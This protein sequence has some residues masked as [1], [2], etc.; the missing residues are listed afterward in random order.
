MPLTIIRNDLT[1]VKADAIV[2]TANKT[3][4]P[5]GGVCGAVFAAA[6]REALAAECA[7]IGG[8]Q[9]GQAVITGAHA[10]PAKYII[11]TVA[12]VWRG[13]GHGEAATLA[14][15]YTA[16]LGLAVKHGC[17][18]VAFP[19]IASGVRGYPKDAALSAAVST[20][21][22]FLMKHELTVFLVVFDQKAYA[23]SGKLF[24]D[25]QS[26]IDQHYVD[27]HFEERRLAPTEE[28]MAAIA[29]KTLEDALK[30]LDES[31]SRRLLRLIAEKGRTQVETYK[32]ANLDR[33]LFSKIRKSEHYLP[34][35][36]T[37]L[38]LAVALELN[39]AETND[40]LA[41]AGLT[42]SH[43]NR[44]DL[45]IEYFI[46]AGRYNIFEINE[47]LFCQDLPLLGA[48]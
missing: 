14:A 46:Q 1:K 16:S 27:E 22:E 9:P 34:T 10:L 28:K 15:C 43:S 41:R 48:F 25:I 31:F 18:S 40:L 13:G 45:I 24:A 33:K 39:L 2:N 7:K 38:A 3:L 6:G 5:G 47:T 36:A 32:K 26:Y 35:K 23:L 44:F 4:T 11:H 21:G 37:A 20:I 42:L 29:P 30:R 12:P 17:R 8:C 19:L